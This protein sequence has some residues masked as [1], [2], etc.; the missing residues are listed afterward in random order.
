MYYY[1]SK[2]KAVSM[3]KFVNGYYQK[4]AQKEERYHNDVRKPTAKAK[5]GFK[6]DPNTSEGKGMIA[7]ICI[8]VI[9]LAVGA[10]MWK[11]KEMYAKYKENHPSTALATFG[12][13]CGCSS[14]PTASFKFY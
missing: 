14:A 3:D 4:K 5:E 11:G 6:L 1:D 7:G 12:G 10:W 13:G 8:V 9:L 2:G